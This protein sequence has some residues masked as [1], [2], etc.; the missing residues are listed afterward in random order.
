MNPA[1]RIFYLIPIP[2]QTGDIV[3]LYLPSDLITQN[4]EITSSLG[5]GVLLFCELRII[6]EKLDTYRSRLL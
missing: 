4:A 5:F 6:E 2:Q 1:D 3:N